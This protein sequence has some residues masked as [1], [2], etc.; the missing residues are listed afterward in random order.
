MPARTAATASPT[1]GEAV[2][3]MTVM[4]G[5]GLGTMRIANRITVPARDA[6][7][8][9]DSHVRQGHVV[10]GGWYYGDGEMRRLA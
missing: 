1:T 6:G 9:A 8:R 5:S 4:A 10:L 2:V 7:W 3:R